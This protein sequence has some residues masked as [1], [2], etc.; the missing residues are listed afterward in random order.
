MA[1]VAA[2]TKVAPGKVITIPRLELCAAHLLIATIR[3]EALRIDNVSYTLWSDSTIVLHAIH[4]KPS[5]LKQFVSNRV[6]YI[7]AHTK[8]EC[9]RHIRSEYNPTD[10][11]S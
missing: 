1:L 6:E 10:C 8:V 9:W 2:K 4:K 5:T 3:Q 7:Q 11:A